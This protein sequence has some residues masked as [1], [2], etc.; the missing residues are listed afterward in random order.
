MAGGLRSS[1]PQRSS[2]QLRLLYYD[3]KL[4][5]T[6]CNLTCAAN[7]IALVQTSVACWRASLLSRGGEGPAVI[8]VQG[9]GGVLNGTSVFAEMNS[10]SYRICFGL[11]GSFVQNTVYAE[12]GLIIS[13]QNDHLVLYANQRIQQSPLFV[14]GLMV[15]IFS[16]VLVIC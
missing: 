7:Q 16:T 6:T 10:T 4:G 9:S 3:S 13:V 11:Q 14:P 12:T 2:S 15:P 5:A 8:L 1:L